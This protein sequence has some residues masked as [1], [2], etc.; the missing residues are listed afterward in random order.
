MNSC[1]GNILNVF[2][3]ASDSCNNTDSSVTPFFYYQ[4]FTARPGQT[5]RCTRIQIPGNVVNSFVYTNDGIENGTCTLQLYKSDSC[6][7]KPRTD[8]GV[9]QDVSGCN[10]ETFRAAKLSCE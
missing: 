6:T 8:Y 10:S 3:F 1:T 9:N 2:S 4:K 7:D 5:T